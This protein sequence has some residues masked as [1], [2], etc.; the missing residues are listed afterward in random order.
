M[1]IQANSAHQVT[2]SGKRELTA[3]LGRSWSMSEALSN[4]AD[5]TS[6]RFVR[7]FDIDI[8]DTTL[9]AAA[10][11][12]ARRAQ[13]REATRISF[14][15][16]HCVNI[17]YRNQTY[18]RAV[19]SSDRVFADG[20]GMAIAAR[21]AGVALLDN[22]NGTD[23]FPVLCSRAARAGVSIFLFGGKQGI[24]DRAATR[25]S[26]MVP[27]LAIAG[28]H[29]GYIQREQ[30]ESIIE[31][32]NAS[33]A[34]ILLVGLGVPEQELWIAR[35]SHRLAPAVIVGVG[36]LF[37]YYSGRIAR[38]PRIMR[39]TGTEW[40]WRL[41]KEPRRLARRYLLG[42]ITFL[43]RLAFLRVAKPRL[44]DQ[45]QAGRGHGGKPVP[46]L[47]AFGG[48]RGGAEAR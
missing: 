13:A 19:E 28:T 42:N 27:S 36:G 48:P 29:H 7:L 8:Y 5:E 39:A 11:W 46:G 44:F 40:V 20:S 21:S 3:A 6:G 26:D 17:M 32:I 16:A 47:H 33:G 18:R 35:H 45:R 31:M 22:V 10:E 37:D 2:T 9:E 23:L 12:I 34:E 43:A 15:N 24:A 14:V 1:V 30:D 41:A 25:V 4:P 38:A